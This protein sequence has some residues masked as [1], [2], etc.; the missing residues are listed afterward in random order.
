MDSTNLYYNYYESGASSPSISKMIPW[1]LF[2]QWCPVLLGPNPSDV[3]TTPYKVN[4]INA[5]DGRRLR[6]QFRMFSIPYTIDTTN[7]MVFSGFE[8]YADICAI[9][10]GRSGA[11]ILYV[12][13]G[14]HSE[15]WV[16]S[17]SLMKINTGETGRNLTITKATDGKSFTLTSNNSDRG[18]IFGCSLGEF[19]YIFQ[20]L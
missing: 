1:N 10:L 6:A 13:C 7:K 20:A 12:K 16:D 4:D 5:T 17:S 9:I 2:N 11:Y 14:T 3:A 15:C 8:N 19:S 18:N